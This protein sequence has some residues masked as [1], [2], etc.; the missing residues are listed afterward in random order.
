MDYL[1]WNNHRMSSEINS[2]SLGHLKFVSKKY[3]KSKDNFILKGKPNNTLLTRL[4]NPILKPGSQWHKDAFSESCWEPT[5]NSTEPQRIISTT[6][7]G[8]QPDLTALRPSWSERKLTERDQEEEVH[9]QDFRNQDHPE[10]PKTSYYWD[11]CFPA[12]G[13]SVTYLTSWRSAEQ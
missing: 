3:H 10:A 12:C 9:Y 8:G 11:S 1:Q 2:S 6:P 4:P 5:P 7:Q 13:H